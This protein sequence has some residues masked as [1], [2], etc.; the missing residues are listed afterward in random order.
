MHPGVRRY[1]GKSIVSGRLAACLRETLRHNGQNRLQ[2]A[3]RALAAAITALRAE[4]AERDK[5]ERAMEKIIVDA[6]SI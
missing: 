5:L 6:A 4:R 1:Q 3:T 2:G